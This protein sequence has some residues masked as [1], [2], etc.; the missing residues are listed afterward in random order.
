M[1]FLFF[2]IPRGAQVFVTEERIRIKVSVEC[3]KVTG[4]TWYPVFDEHSVELII[5]Y[6]S[7]E[8]TKSGSLQEAQLL[9]SLP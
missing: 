8:L 9:C 3:H 5:L 1:V 4:I 7:V 2:I 6:G